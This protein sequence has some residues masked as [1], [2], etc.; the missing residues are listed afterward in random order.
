MS[1]AAL[2]RRLRFLRSMCRQKRGLHKDG[3]RVVC[4]PLCTTA[5][6]PTYEKSWSTR[7]C[8]PGCH[9]SMSWIWTPSSPESFERNVHGVAAD[10]DSSGSDDWLSPSAYQTFF[11]NGM[12]LP[13]FLPVPPPEF[14]PAT[15]SGDMFSSGLQSGPRCF[16]TGVRA[17]GGFPTPVPIHACTAPRR[18]GRIMHQ[19]EDAPNGGFGLASR[20]QL[21]RA[22]S[23]RD[24]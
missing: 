23:G 11:M 7:K 2:R 8:K 20:H 14:P 13:H 9:G 22:H 15:A 18:H 21:A 3:R 5:Y 24:T 10:S 6:N 16:H 1:G 4:S 12:N 19:P 17:T